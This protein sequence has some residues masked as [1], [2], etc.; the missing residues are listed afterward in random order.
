MS[1]DGIQI[2]VPEVEVVEPEKVRSKHAAKHPLAQLGKASIP[3][4]F[5]SSKQAAVILNRASGMS[6]EDSAI[7]AGYHAANSNSAKVMASAALKKNLS[8]NSK[9]MEHLKEHCVDMDTVAQKLAALLEAKNT[10]RVGREEYV[11]VPDNKTQL[12]TC[13]LLVKVMNAEP[14]KKLEI[15]EK[16]TFEQRIL[17]LSHVT[18]EHIDGHEE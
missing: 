1:D 18:V 5:M 16:L 4:G 6:L 17:Q 13:E 9:F 12:S 3:D 2:M 15:E 14:P 7:A 11:E 10:V 8:P